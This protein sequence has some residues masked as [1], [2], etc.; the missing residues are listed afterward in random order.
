MRNVTITLEDE[1]ARWVRVWA[2]EHDTSVSQFV[3]DLVKKE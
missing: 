3:G 2:V 1:V